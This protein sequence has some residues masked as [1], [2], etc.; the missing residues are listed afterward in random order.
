[1][2]QKD[3]EDLEEVSMELELADEDEKIPYVTII[4]YFS[5]ACSSYQYPLLPLNKLTFKKHQNKDIKLETHSF[6]F[7]SR[8]HN[9]SSQPPRSELTMRS[10][11]S[12]KT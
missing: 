4:P 10:A 1:M 3:K 8:K 9:L 2:L 6:P 5:L 7:P 11:S 12:K